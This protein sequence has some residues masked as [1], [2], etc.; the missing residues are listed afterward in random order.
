MEMPWP[1]KRM[2]LWKPAARLNWERS[3]EPMIAEIGR[4]EERHTQPDGPQ[5]QKHLPHR[6]GDEGELQQSCRDQ[7]HPQGGKDARAHPVG[8]APV[9]GER[10]PSARAGQQ[11]EPPPERT[12]QDDLHEHGGEVVAANTAM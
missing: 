11:D 5:R 2:V 8:E 6:S 4:A 1:V 12:A 10:T 3:T 7:H 9:K